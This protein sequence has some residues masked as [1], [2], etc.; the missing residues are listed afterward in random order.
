MQRSWGQGEHDGGGGQ[1]EREHG[2]RTG[3]PQVSELVG[4]EGSEPHGISLCD[5]KPQAVLNE[6]SDL[7]LPWWS[8][9]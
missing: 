3:H 4:E 5:E 1:C 9:D 6:A 7:G 8:G 2:D